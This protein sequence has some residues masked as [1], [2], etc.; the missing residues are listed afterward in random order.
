MTQQFN[1]LSVGEVARR[2]GVRP[3][4]ITQLFYERRLRE[5]LCP[6]VAGRRL[7]PDDYLSLIAAELRRKGVAV[8]SD[9]R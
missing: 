9:E 5:D 2:L 6:L 7:I 4:Q 8:G 1:Y 3:Q